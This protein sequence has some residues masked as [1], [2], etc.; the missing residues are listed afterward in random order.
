MKYFN[1]NTP[2]FND[3]QSLAMAN[4]ENGMVMI[5]PIPKHN[6]PKKLIPNISIANCSSMSM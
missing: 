2:S 3:K 1:Y 5:K 4:K 6:K